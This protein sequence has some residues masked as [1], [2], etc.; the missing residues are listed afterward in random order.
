[1]TGRIIETPE[2]VAEGAAH[3]AALEPRFAPRWS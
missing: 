2:D 1:M 3:L